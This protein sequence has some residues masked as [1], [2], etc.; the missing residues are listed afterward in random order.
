LC[1]HAPGIFFSAK[2]DERDEDDNLADDSEYE[3]AI[4]RIMSIRE[5]GVR[6]SIPDY[7]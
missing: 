5:A 2:Q 1:V 6:K 4:K 7:F 3:K